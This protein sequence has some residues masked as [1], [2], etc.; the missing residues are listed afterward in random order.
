MSK[1]RQYASSFAARA[2]AK[3]DKRWG[4]CPETGHCFAG[5]PAQLAALS[6]VPKLKDDALATIRIK[7]EGGSQN[8]FTRT[9]SENCH[10]IYYGNK[11]NIETYRRTPRRDAE[12]RV[13]FALAK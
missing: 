3:G 5:T 10:V 12:G 2:A 11:P 1:A 6:I 9:S 7:Y 13:I 8:G 4:V